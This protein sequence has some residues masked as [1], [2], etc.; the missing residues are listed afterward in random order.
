M[1]PMPPSVT[2]SEQNLSKFSPTTTLGNSPLSNESPVALSPTTKLSRS[3]VVLNTLFENILQ[4]TLKQANAIEPI[5]YMGG[6]GGDS[7]MVTADDITG[8][9]CNRLLESQEVNGGIGYLVGCY[10]RLIQKQKDYDNTSNKTDKVIAENLS[11]CKEELVR[12]IGSGTNPLSSTPHPPPLTRTSSTLSLTPSHSLVLTEPE[13]FGKNSENSKNDFLNTLITQ[14]SSSLGSVNSHMFLESLLS[15]LSDE[16]VD[17]ISDIV[18]GIVTK[19]FQELNENNTPPTTIPSMM[20]LP[21]CRSIMK[22]D[23]QTPVLTPSYSLT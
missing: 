23:I 4:I 16:I 22:N 12:F 6:N 17:N 8:L 13:A 2:L 21:L 7:D 9:L 5:K 20:M 14:S 18:V 1:P 3:V 10:K 11:R 19:A 15:S